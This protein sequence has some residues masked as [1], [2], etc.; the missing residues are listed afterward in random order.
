MGW[1]RLRMST[2]AFLQTML[3]NR[4]PMPLMAVMAYMT[5]CLPSTLVFSTRRMCWNSSPATRDCRAACQVG[6]QVSA[7]RRCHNASKNTQL[8]GALAQLCRR[9]GAGSGGKHAPP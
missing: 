6:Q 5:F 9:R 4:R 8:T 3:A 1:Y 7:R 2:S